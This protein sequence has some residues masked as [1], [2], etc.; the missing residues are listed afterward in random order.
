MDF[1]TNSLVRVKINHSG[2]WAQEWN[3]C[4][5]KKKKKID[6][7]DKTVISVA[8][9]QPHGESRQVELIITKQA[10]SIRE[11]RQID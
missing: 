2:L 9:K 4:V 6:E 3:V 1:T 11:L 10:N 7:E 5:Q 8:L